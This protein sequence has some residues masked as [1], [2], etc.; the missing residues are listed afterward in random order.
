[1]KN[2]KVIFTDTDYELVAKAYKQY[3]KLTENYQFKSAVLELLSLI[4]IVSG[5]FVMFILFAV[6][7]DTFIGSTIVFGAAVLSIILVALS[8]VY[9]KKNKTFTTYR[10]DCFNVKRNME[11]LRKN[12]N[13]I[14]FGMD[15][16]CNE[17][18]YDVCNLDYEYR[19]H[20]SSVANEIQ[21]TDNIILK[22]KETVDKHGFVSYVWQ[23]ESEGC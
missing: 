23:T 4:T 21:D 1:M 5:F 15:I 20:M 2:V 3:D 6:T 9:D 19:R 12:D 10:A 16:L 17:L 14:H 7:D 11:E 13:E 8:A 22:L 18:F